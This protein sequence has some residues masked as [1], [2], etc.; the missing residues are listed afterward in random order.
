MGDSV[1]HNKGITVVLQELYSLET[2]AGQLF[3]GTHTTLGFVAGTNKMLR[4]L[5][6]E[7]KTEQVLKGFMV[8]LEVD[9][10]KS[11]IAGQALD[12]CL[13]LVAGESIHKPWNRYKG[14]PAFP[15]AE[16]SFQPFVCL[17]RR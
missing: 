1:H 13:K 7:Q 16:R 14:V 3:C 12:I 4:N 9:S 6:A 2:P 15:P 17:H 10:K 8:D 11:S 5:E